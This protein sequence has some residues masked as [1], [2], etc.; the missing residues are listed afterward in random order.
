MTL[1]Q[2]A[3]L[4]GVAII[5]IIIIITSLHQP[6]LFLLPLATFQQEIPQS[7]PFASHAS[8]PRPSRVR[9]CPYNK[10]FVRY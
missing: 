10:L 4:V 7:H 8:H 5:I 9:Q 3:R 2:G 6:V 1:C